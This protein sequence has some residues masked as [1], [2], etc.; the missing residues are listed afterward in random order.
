MYIRVLV[1]LII[2][3][4]FSCKNISERTESNEEYNTINL[5]YATLFSVKYYKN[6]RELTVFGEN[7]KSFTKYYLVDKKDK[8]PKFLSNENIIRTPVE[9]VVCTSTTHIAFIDVLGNSQ[10]IIGVSGGD[11]IYNNNIKKRIKNDLVYDVG[12]GQMLDYEKLISLRPDLITIYNVDGEISPVI[13]KLKSLKIP[14]VLVNEYSE[15][16]ILGQTEW[17]KFFGEFYDKQKISDEIFSSICSRY[18]NLKQIAA[19]T[20]N[21]PA[22]M[23]N[24]PWKG[25]WYIPGNN[26]NAAQLINDAGGA[27]K[28]INDENLRNFPT[29]ISNVFI[30]W[31]E[32]KFWLNPGQAMSVNDI[33]LTD[34][35][36]AMF[37][38][39][40]N[41]KIYNRINRISE[42][43][44]NDF[45]ESGVVKPDVILKDIIM[46]L[47]PELNISDSLFF[48]KKL[49]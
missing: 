18:N 30:S 13:S 29:D 19:K 3:T 5:N 15:Q 26:S 6:Y 12:Y 20:G 32:T 28:S 45:M 38:P 4:F 8:I 49:Y 25:V 11:Y 7:K 46:I 1:F 35:R 2:I 22:V 16:N 23:L 17:L 27:Y 36:L 33:V 44:G 14:V 10:T 48:Y 37:E 41:K 24:M 39:F 21:K 31:S 40:K 9:R 43:G 47:H 34:S 42:S